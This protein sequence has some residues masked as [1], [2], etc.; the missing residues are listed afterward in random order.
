MGERVRGLRVQK[1][2]TQP[3]L[4]E[5]SGIDQST[6]SKIENGETRSPHPVTLRAIAA[7]VGDWLRA[8]RQRLRLEQVEARSWQDQGLVFPN[9]SG[10]PLHGPYVTREMQ[11]VMAEA[12]IKRRRFHDLRHTAASMLL[13]QGVDMRTIQQVLGHASYQLT[14]DTYAHPDEQLLRSAADKMGAVLRR[15]AAGGTSGGTS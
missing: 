11:R 2:W 15:A 12:G 4:A 3:E 6:I 5:A 10:G 1:G 8:Q 7:E 14:A 13:A 9:T